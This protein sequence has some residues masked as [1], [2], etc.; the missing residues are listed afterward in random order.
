MIL[1]EHP[2]SLLE[3]FAE[4]LLCFC[5]VAAVLEEL[6]QV[7][8]LVKRRRILLSEYSPRPAYRITQRRFS[9]I[10]LPHR[11]LKPPELSN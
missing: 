2:P 3:R 7:V 8:D 9:L 11:L 5:K 6:S 10:Q 1:A 4:Q